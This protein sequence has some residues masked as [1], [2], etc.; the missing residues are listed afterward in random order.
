MKA[1]KL[2]SATATLLFAAQLWAADYAIIVNSSYADNSISSSDLKSIY[3]GQKTSLGNSKAEPCVLAGP[4]GKDFYQ[5]VL[6][7]PQ[8][9]FAQAWV[10][11]ELSGGGTAPVSRDSVESVV[12]FVSQTKGGI[13]FVPAA[14]KDR[15]DGAKAK[16]I[17]VR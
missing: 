12:N 8:K 2:F 16:V 15:V 11:M 4:E 10:R 5:S 9:D 6:E 14:A 1:L 17:S 7:V 3:L 13:C